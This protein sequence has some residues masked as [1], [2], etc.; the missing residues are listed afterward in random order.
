MLNLNRNAEIR[1]DVVTRIWYN[2]IR[3]YD[4]TEPGW[5][6]SEYIPMY[7]SGADIE[8]KFTNNHQNHHIGPTA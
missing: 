5:R 6:K 4:F 7:C 8:I 3:Q 2:E 1:G